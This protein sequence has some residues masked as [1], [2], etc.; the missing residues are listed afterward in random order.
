MEKDLNK[1]NVHTY[2]APGAIN[3]ENIEHVENLYPGSNELL[4]GKSGTLPTRLLTD[5]ELREKINAVM[6]LIKSSRHWFPIVKVLMFRGQIKMNDFKGGQKRIEGLYP[7]GL[8]YPLNYADL[9]RMNV[10]S[11]A[12]PIDSWNTNDGPI[13]RPAEFK[14]YVTIAKKFDGLF[15]FK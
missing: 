7:A 5:D 14:I 3:I 2:V 4:A 9:M 1:L 6:N 15:S 8:E 11:F 10:G 12:G 13:K